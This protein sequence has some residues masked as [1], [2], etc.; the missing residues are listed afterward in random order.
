VG[1]SKC[2][3][4]ISGAILVVRRSNYMVYLVSFRDMITARTTDG[5]RIDV[6]NHRVGSQ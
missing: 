4:K 2:S 1:E 3:N 5:R 6:S